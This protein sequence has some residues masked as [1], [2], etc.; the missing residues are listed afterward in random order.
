VEIQ[1]VVIAVPDYERAK[2][3][4]DLA[5]AHRQRNS[6]KN[7]TSFGMQ[8]TAHSRW[9]RRVDG[10]DLPHD[11]CR[12]MIME[13]LPSGTSLIE[14]YQWEYLRMNKRSCSAGRKSTRPT[15]RTN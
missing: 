9:Y 11:T 5:D 12:I 6:P 2:R 4:S 1:K 14:R 8:R 10:I 15:L 13:G 7:W 3:W